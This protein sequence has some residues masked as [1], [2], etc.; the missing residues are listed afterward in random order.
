MT[1]PRTGR[2]E[3]RPWGEPEEPALPEAPAWG[4]T[5]LPADPWGSPATPPAAPEPVAAEPSAWGAAEPAQPA[6]PV[7]PAWGAAPEAPE[8]VAPAWNAPAE[9]A[10]PAEPVAPAWG[11]APQAPEPAPQAW[12]QPPAQPAEP[13]APAWGAAPQAPEPAPQAWQQPPAQPVQ[14][15]PQAWQQPAQTAWQQPGSQQPGWQQQ[16]A[17][18]GWQQPGTQAGWQQPGAQASWQQQPGAQPGWQQP[19]TQQGWQQAAPPQTWQQT[20][21]TWQ[22][23][24]AAAAGW[25]ATGAVVSTWEV[26]PEPRAPRYQRSIVVV[27]A[28]LVLLFSGLGIVSFGGALLAVGATVDLPGFLSSISEGAIAL[29]VGDAVAQLVGLLGGTIVVLGIVQTLA[30][31]LI[32]AHRT[33]GRVLGILI[34][35]IGILFGGSI[36]FV[37]GGFAGAIESMTVTIPGLPGDP[38]LE[39]ASLAGDT[40]V[41]APFAGIGIVSFLILFALLVGGRHFRRS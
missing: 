18:P 4:A 40:G 21:G 20:P 12:Q 14:P 19:G 9:P 24:D 11:A 31:L 6:E 26:P 22:Q 33:L 2:D 3:E 37:V 35:L 8:P 27:L 34:A 5:P 39:L 28:G 41:I 30:A 36:A 29:S 7:A 10:Q 38:S 15:A 1:D 13:V 17:Q 32:L 23:A 25:T 16:P